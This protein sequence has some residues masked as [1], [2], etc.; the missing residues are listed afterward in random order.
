MS[1][2]WGGRFVEKSDEFFLRFN[3]SLGFDCELLDA[4]IRASVAYGS[5]LAKVGILMET[6]FDSIKSALLEMVEDRKTAKAELKTAIDNGVEDIHSFV[7]MLLVRKLG[8]LG[9]KLHTGRSRNE[10]VA[11][12]LRIYLKDRVKEMTQTIDNLQQALTQQ[13]RAGEDA[14]LPGYT[15]LQ[16]AQPILW[17]HYLLSWVESFERDKS[18]LSDAYKRIDVMPLGSGALSGNALGFD[19]DR[20][21]NALG[22]AAIS[23]NSLD[24]TS[25][26]DFVLETLFC[27]S[28][29]MLHLSRLAEDLII[30]SSKEYGFVRMSDKVATG[31]SL[32]PQKRNPDALELIRGKTGRV[33]GNLNALMITI[34]GLP[35]A[36]NKDMQE[37]KEGVFDSI[38]QTSDCLNVMTTVVS[39]L[40]INKQTMEAA[41]S[42]GYLN[43]TDL[44]DYFVYKGVPFRKAH[45]MVGQIVTNAERQN[46]RLEEL[47]LAQFRVYYPES[48]NEIYEYLDIRKALARKNV[49]GGTAPSRVKSLLT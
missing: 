44:A 41:C 17:P 11:T 19:R 32:M 39:T 12:D 46:K 10:Q 45:E 5:E 4:E 35:S 15:H 13:A 48:D 2:L 9:Y 1:K 28:T 26:R 24:A 33:I 3:Q 34:K 27:L 43:A 20:L 18:R 37:D 7:E 30:Y 47:S 38:K 31:S 8:T 29:T 25:D 42:E 21:K 16:R 49:H 22:F 14:I 36:Y 23:N 6:E 40:Q